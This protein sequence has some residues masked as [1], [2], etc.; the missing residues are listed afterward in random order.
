MNTYAEMQQT[1]LGMTWQEVMAQVAAQD[2]KCQLGNKIEEEQLK[3]VI[4]QSLQDVKKPAV[5]NHFSPQY[6]AQ[7][8]KDAKRISGK[9][10]ILVSG[11]KFTDFMATG[12]AE[13]K[14]IG[15]GISVLGK[16]WCFTRL[17]KPV[18]Y[19]DWEQHKKD[20]KNGTFILIDENAGLFVV[21]EFKGRPTRT[22][23]RFSIMIPRSAG[24]CVLNSFV[25][26]CFGSSVA[27]FFMSEKSSTIR[28]FI[29]IYI[30]P[31]HN[32]CAKT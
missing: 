3:W 32:G 13:I 31:N 14:C 15:S 24:T 12:N 10:F 6:W 8:A 17:G 9:D 29:P 22:E 25:G 1:Q 5:V 26:E 28:V 4:E 27:H 20:S 19:F 11:E 7:V 23:S 21:T 2:K 18:G 30:Y 16:E